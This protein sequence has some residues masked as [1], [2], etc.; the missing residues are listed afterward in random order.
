MFSRLCDDDV[1]VRYNTLTVLTHLVLN[2]MI[3]VK[4]QVSHVVMCLVDPCARVRDLSAML[5]TRL[6]ERSNNPVYNLLGDIIAILSRDKTTAAAT[7]ATGKGATDDESA[8]VEVAC[9]ES[10]DSDAYLPKRS[11]TQEEFQTVMHFLLS[12]VKNTKQA[13]GLLERLLMRLGLAQTGG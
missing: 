10:T 13:D 9:V 3:K 2:D 4:G 5:F 1:T 8:A 6:S 11:L 7:T 12:F